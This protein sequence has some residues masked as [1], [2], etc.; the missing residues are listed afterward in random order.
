MKA[1]FNLP[2]LGMNTFSYEGKTAV[3]SQYELEE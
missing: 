3:V 1:T 2:G